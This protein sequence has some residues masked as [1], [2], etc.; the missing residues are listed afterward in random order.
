M[1]VGTASAPPALEEV[2][3][4]DPNTS[5]SFGPGPLLTSLL[6]GSVIPGRWE[7]LDAFESGSKIV[8]SLKSGEKARY[9]FLN[10]DSGSLTVKDRGGQGLVI[11]R[12]HVTRVVKQNMRS[13]TPA[14]VGAAVGAGAGAAFGAALS[15][16]YVP[17]Y[18]AVTFGLIG[19]LAGFTTG[20]CITQKPA[21]E[22]LYEV[23]TNPTGGK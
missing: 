1:W 3:N 8:L 19:A 20:Y 23:S 5:D 12:T 2:R 7:K 6:P 9:T 16:D 17:E 14:W 11:P 18:F 22:S 15:G 4:E 10:S 13:T 21:D